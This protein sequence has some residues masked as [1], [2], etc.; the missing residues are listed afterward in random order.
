[1]GAQWRLKRTSKFPSR[2][3][4]LLSLNSFRAKQQ[5]SKDF[6]VVDQIVKRVVK[7]NYVG[8]KGPQQGALLMEH[9]TKAE[10]GQK[11]QRDG[12]KEGKRRSA[13]A[14]AGRWMPMQH[15]WRSNCEQREEREGRGEEAAQA[16]CQSHTSHVAVVDLPPPRPA[17]S[18]PSI[19]RSHL[20]VRMSAVFLDTASDP[21]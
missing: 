6:E 7:L 8:T 20:P 17:C 21:R 18:L 9:Q 19:P 10:S 11:R 4:L 14:V 16:R 13:G 3:V 2:N 5:T 15:V 1:M 12:K